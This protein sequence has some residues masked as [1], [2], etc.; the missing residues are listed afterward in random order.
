MSQLMSGKASFGERAARRLEK[1]YGMGDR[2]LDQEIDLVISEPSGEVIVAQT[3]DVDQSDRRYEVISALRAAAHE[4][5]SA[6]GLLCTDIPDAISKN[7]AFQLDFSNT[8]AQLDRAINIAKSPLFGRSPTISGDMIDIP[9][10]DVCGSMGPG[11]ALPDHDE[12]VERMIV[13]GAW[14]R[15]NVSSTATGN[16]ALITGYG[17]SMEGTFSDG[18]LLLVDRGVVDIKIDGVFVLAL[19]DELYIKRLQRRP[20]GTVLMISDNKKYE[21]FLIQNGDREKFTVLGRVLLAWNAKK[22]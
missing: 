13:S 9:V 16:L 22:L 12:V 14:L 17:D 7:V 1:D 10:L 5:D 3:K 6:H 2:Y 21:P 15:R 18:D 4:L 8:R 19:N 20:D 11:L